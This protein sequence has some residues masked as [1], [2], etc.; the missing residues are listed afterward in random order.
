MGTMF[1]SSLQKNTAYFYLFV[2]NKDIAGYNLLGI[3]CH[4][5][6]TIME[7]VYKGNNTASFFSL[8]APPPWKRKF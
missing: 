6:C 1:T 3:Y 8:V 4:N 7:E 2:L 5:I